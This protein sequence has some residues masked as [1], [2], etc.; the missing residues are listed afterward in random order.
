MNNKFTNDEYKKSIKN[1]SPLPI[2]KY[3]RI[4]RYF[5]RPMASLIVRAVYKTRIT[6][7]FLTIFSFVIGLLGAAAYF[8]GSHIFFIAGGILAQL[9]SIFD[10]ADGQLARAKNIETRYGAYLDLLLDRFSDSIVY[11]G[12]IFGYFRYS[13]SWEWLIIGLTSL[14]LYNLQTNLYYVSKQYF[15]MDKLGDRAEARGF[16]VFVILILSLVNRLEFVFMGILLM[17]VLN[18]GYRLFIFLWK[19]RKQP[20]NGSS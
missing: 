7:N 12:M 9:S 17:T 20:F 19:E 18:I 5:T 4:E 14:A 3:I 2:L 8:G 15:K 10:C 1:N 6:P 11:L 13:G 16:A